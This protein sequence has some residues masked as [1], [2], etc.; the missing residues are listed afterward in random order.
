MNITI[1]IQPQ[2]FKSSKYLDSENCYLAEALKN[3]GYKNVSVFANK[4]E[5]GSKTYKTKEPFYHDLV[6]KHF[7]ENKSISLTLIE[8]VYE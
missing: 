4:I 1:T 6:K 2:I 3:I 8:Q 7:K 5:I